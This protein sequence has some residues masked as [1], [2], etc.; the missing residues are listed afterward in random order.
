M[1]RKIV[2]VISLALL[3]VVISILNFFKNVDFKTKG[4][5]KSLCT[6]TRVVDG[7][8]IELSNSETVRYIG[9]DTPELREKKG[10][11]WV[12]NPRP[13]AED[14]K[15]FNKAL[16]EG[17][18]V[19]LE[20]D[21][22]KRDRYKRLLAYVYSEDK[23]I[24]LEMIKQGYAMI[25]THPP[26]VR[27]AEKFLEAQRYARE[28]K[29]GLWAG[30]DSENA[31]ISTTQAKENIGKIKV[32]EAVVSDT[33]LTEKVLILKFKNRFKAVIYKD[34][35]MHFPKAMQRSPDTYLKGKT[36]KVYGLIKDYKG[37][38]EIIIHDPSQIEILE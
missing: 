9:I 35:L 19:R 5:N 4:L 28:N 30:L 10:S 22:E 29:K 27:Y 32:I 2:R 31:R 23:M 24:N 11:K 17:K 3:I 34:T 37:S 14:A 8:T 16:A 25:Y 26:N 18:E 21:V 13:Y 12:Y 15:S 7:D 1:K 38:P 6:V 20:F 36:V 33:H